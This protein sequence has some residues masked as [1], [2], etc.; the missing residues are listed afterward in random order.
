MKIGLNREL[1]ALR[2]AREF[3]DGMYVNL[4][5]GLPAY[6]ANFIP[7]DIEVIL[8]AENGVLGYGGVPDNEA[9]WDRELVNSSAQPTSLKPGACFFDSATSFAMIRGGHID[10]VVLGAYQ[11]SEKGDI[12]NWARAGGEQFGVGGAMDLA[13]GAIKRVLAYMEHT[14]KKGEA[15]IVRECTYPVTGRGVV[16]TIFTNLAVIEVTQQGLVLKEIAPGITVEQV[17]ESTQA[18][19]IV[20]ADLTEMVL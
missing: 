10:L 3:K 18:D 7:Q 15:R 6:L 12:A 1:I 13:C 17:Q 9:E 16:N 19:L 2:I 11:V 14:T 8:H 4:G 5:F 20:D